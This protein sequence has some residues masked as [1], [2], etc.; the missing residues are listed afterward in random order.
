MDV[1]TEMQDSRKNTMPVHT[2]I[3]ADSGAAEERRGTKQRAARLRQ[4][5]ARLP[6]STGHAEHDGTSPKR[7][8]KNR[9]AK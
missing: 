1:G 9:E 5:A 8:I 6:R 4:S 3:G 2:R 7:K